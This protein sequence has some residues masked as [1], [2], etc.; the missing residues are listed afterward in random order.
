MILVAGPPCGGKTH[1]VAEHRSPNENVLDFDDIVEDLGKPRYEAGP[2]IIRQARVIW[3]ASLP[4][5]DWVIWTA[6]TRQER[7]RF[8]S[9]FGA[10]VIV[11]MAS[12]QVCLERAE[13]ERPSTW[14]KHIREWFSAWAPSTSG[15]E[16]IVR[17]D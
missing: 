13:T 16:V 2:D 1:Y 17:T 11:V 10:R 15:M 9:Q 14:Q 6:P 7:G 8:R 5:A 12:M 4:R 3:T